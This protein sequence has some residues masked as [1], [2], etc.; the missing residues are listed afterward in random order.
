VRDGR[1]VL[2]DYSLTKTLDFTFNLTKAGEVY[3]SLDFISYDQAVSYGDMPPGGDLFSLAA[4]FYYIETGRYAY[5]SR[6][7]VD[8][9]EKRTIRIANVMPLIEPALSKIYDKALYADGGNGY[10]TA[11]EMKRDLI[12][13]LGSIKN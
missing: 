9:K 8:V 5:E 10:S 6:N 13:A 4:S 12:A 11:E 2:C 7:I 1:A 3:G